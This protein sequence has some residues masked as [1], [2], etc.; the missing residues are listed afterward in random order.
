MSC[1]RISTSG[2][3]QGNTHHNMVSEY[4]L[5]SWR[6]CIGKDVNLLTEYSNMF[7]N[8]KKYTRLQYSI[9]FHTCV[10]ENST[11]VY[12]GTA[13]HGCVISDSDSFEYYTVNIF[14]LNIFVSK[15]FNSV[16]WSARDMIL[17]YSKYLFL[18]SEWFCT[19]SYSR[20]IHY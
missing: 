3:C 9:K 14:I 8:K 20:N 15:T 18:S 5:Y 12:M 6:L 17:Q 11:H 7:L 1:Y 19:V 4:Y 10:H 13:T 16:F 2:E